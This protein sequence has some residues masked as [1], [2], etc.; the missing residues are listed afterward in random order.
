MAYIVQNCRPLRRQRGRE[1]GQARPTQGPAAAR[2]CGRPSTL[3]PQRAEKHAV[4]RRAS[5]RQKRRHACCARMEHQVM[6]AQAD[7]SRSGHEVRQCT[8]RSI[9]E[10]E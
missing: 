6:M 5:L 8:G 2:V 10:R 7:D 1:G 3:P 4:V 9:D